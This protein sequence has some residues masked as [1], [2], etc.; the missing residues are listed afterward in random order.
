MFVNVPGCLLNVGIPLWS[1]AS[2]RA[3]TSWMVVLGLLLAVGLGGILA[4]YSW[5]ESVRRPKRVPL[6]LVRGRVAA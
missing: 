5:S 3:P 4:N 2:F 6:A 1:V